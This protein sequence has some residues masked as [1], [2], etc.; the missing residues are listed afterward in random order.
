MFLITQCYKKVASYL[1]KLKYFLLQDIEKEEI[2]SLLD[3]MYLGHVNVKQE[4][5][6]NLLKAAECLQIKGMLDTIFI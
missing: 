2:E 5:L 4:K 1:A 3:Y 6:N